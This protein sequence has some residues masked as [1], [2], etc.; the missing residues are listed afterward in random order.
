[1]A[2]IKPSVKVTKAKKEVEVV[3]KVVIVQE[4]NMGSYGII[5]T[6]KEDSALADLDGKPVRITVELL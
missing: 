5:L 6:E 4:L 1:M 2:K 3:T